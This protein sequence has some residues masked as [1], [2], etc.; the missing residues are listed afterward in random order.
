MDAGADHHPAPASGVGAAG[1]AQGSLGRVPRYLVEAARL[2]T[3]LASDSSGTSS[4]ASDRGA[5]PPASA[6]HALLA[7]HPD[8]T[9]ALAALLGVEPVWRDT[10]SEIPP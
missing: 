6:V 1:P 9:N 5:E 8:T 3:A 4:R 2:A 7:A 10:T